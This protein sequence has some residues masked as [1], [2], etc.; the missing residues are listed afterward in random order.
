MSNKK[1]SFNPVYPRSKSEFDTEVP[2]LVIQG[3]LFFQTNDYLDMQCTQCLVHE[4]GREII[5][6][7]TKRVE[8]IERNTSRITQ[9]MVEW[10]AGE[11]F[12]MDAFSTGTQSSQLLVQMESQARS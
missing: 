8:D 7:D 1:K 9:E 12:L 4:L 10:E 6:R 3:I 2:R 5:V 11:R